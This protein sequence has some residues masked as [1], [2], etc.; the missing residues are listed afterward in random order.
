[1]LSPTWSFFV[2]FFQLHPTPYPHSRLF[3]T[4]LVVLVKQKTFAGEKSTNLLGFCIKRHDDQK[5]PVFWD[6]EKPLLSAPCLLRPPVPNAHVGPPAQGRWK[7]LL[8]EVGAE[9]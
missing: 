7:W 3:L 4:L 8:S 5:T 1:M 6:E 2:T 9:L